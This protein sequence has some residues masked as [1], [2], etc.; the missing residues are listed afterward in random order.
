VGLLI[1]A[2]ESA[3]ISS[4]ENF[5]MIQDRHDVASRKYQN[6]ITLSISAHPALLGIYTA[7]IEAADGT[8]EFL[9]Q[10]TTLLEAQRLADERSGCPQP[11]SCPPWSTLT[12][13]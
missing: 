3:I 1:S 5:P 10:T 2:V 6:A 7:V 11:R 9:G 4:S 12:L 13:L 8:P